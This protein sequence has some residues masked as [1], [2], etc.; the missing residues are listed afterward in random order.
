MRGGARC[1]S[2]G[3]YPAALRDAA[4]RE[5]SGRPRPAPWAQSPTSQ[6]WGLCP[7]WA[8]IGEG[9]GAGGVE[10]AGG[11]WTRAPPAA[12][13]LPVPAPFAALP[14]THQSGHQVCAER[15]RRGLDGAGGGEAG[16]GGGRGPELCR[17][18]TQPHRYIH[19]TWGFECGRQ[20]P[21]VSK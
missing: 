16:C 11:G 12:G 21:C 17:P 2:R 13:A 7:R 6:E 20:N 4:G 10:A 9:D 18:V 3:L 19:P 15:R 5:M 8:W 1:V 14:S